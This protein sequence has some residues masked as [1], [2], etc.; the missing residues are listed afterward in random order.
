[1]SS[2][3]MRGLSPMM[4]NSSPAMT[5]PFG[6]AAT[7]PPGPGPLGSSSPQAGLP[8]PAGHHPLLSAALSPA[9]P[10]QGWRG[11]PPAQHAQQ[12]QGVQALGVG[13]LP[14]MPWVPAM[15]QQ[16]MAAQG[17][18]QGPP[19]NAP[20][21]ALLEAKVDFLTRAV[22]D[23]QSEICRM[24]EARRAAA[25]RRASAG[26]AGAPLATQMAMASHMM[27]GGHPHSQ[28]PPG[29]LMRSQRSWLLAAGAAAQRGV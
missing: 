14:P 8:G 28:I 3:N 23:L 25:Q 17:L 13:A 9:G 19:Q 15:M 18:G 5:P 4:M 6:S 24:M 21:L 2:A 27:T 26:V 12:Q 11:A 1:M 16:Q 22:F 10:S 7:L 20:Q 29:T